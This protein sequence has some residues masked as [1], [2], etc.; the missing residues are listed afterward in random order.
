[1]NF[2]PFLVLAAVDPAPPGPA[3]CL[4]EADSTS[5]RPLL[6]PKV[7]CGADYRKG[8]KPLSRSRCS[9]RKAAT[10]SGR[11]WNDAPDQIPQH[12]IT[13]PS[14]GPL[15][16][17]QSLTSIIPT[18]VQRRKQIA[19]VPGHWM[20]CPA[21]V[22]ARLHAPPPAP[23]AAV[24]M[25]G[26]FMSHVPTPICFGGNVGINWKRTPAAQ[27]RNTAWEVAPRPDHPHVMLHSTPECLMVRRRDAGRRD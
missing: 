16:G 20:R 10:S 23:H 17:I 3:A 15:P 12:P 11:I 24:A 27:R 14:A 5:W 21:A 13:K 19:P 8:G 1:M 4:S 9:S 7:I 6:R 2:W 22:V 26:W 25:P 18:T